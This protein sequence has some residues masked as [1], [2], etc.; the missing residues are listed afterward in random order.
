MNKHSWLRDRWSTLRILSFTEKASLFAA[1]TLSCL[2]K[3]GRRIEVRALFVGAT[4][5]QEGYAMAT[6]NREH[7]ERIIGIA[8]YPSKN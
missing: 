3:A 5:F 8:V 2:D 7:F 6:E 4:A 1:K